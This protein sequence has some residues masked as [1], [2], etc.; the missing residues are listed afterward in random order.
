MKTLKYT[1]L[2]SIFIF[3]LACTDEHSNKSEAKAETQEHVVENSEEIRISKGQF[4][5]GDMNLIT[6]KKQAFSEGVMCTGV[7]DVP[8]QSKAI[9]SAIMGGYVKKSNLLIGDRVKKGEVILSIE[10]PDYAD[11][12]QHYL[13]TKAT[14]NYLKEDFERQ[15]TLQDE[16]INS[17][18]DFFKA[19]SD[20]EQANAK[21]QGLAEKLRM[22][23]INPSSVSAENISATVQLFAPIN[24]RISMVNISQGTYVDPSKP[25]MEIIALDHLH[26]ELNVYEKDYL[27]ISIGQK[28]LF[29]I[30]EAS[31]QI[32]EGEVHLIGNTIEQQ[33]RTVK[34]HGHLNT[35]SINF[36]VGMFIEA[37]IVLK[38]EELLAAPNDALIKTEN[39]NELLRLSEETEAEYIFTKETIKTGKIE[40]NKTAILYY[41]NWKA[42]NQY[43]V[44]GYHF[45]MEK[46]GGG[47]GH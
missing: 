22:I 23:S 2:A 39:S 35:D 8:P 29:S 32:F 38:T 42:E 3:Q 36:A 40:S 12:Q 46:N 5:A 17:E 27:K 13:E 1:I 6:L 21:L 45:V 15:K 44:G 37:Q 14:I 28:I 16:K 34:V 9:I 41:T 4:V 47:H 7:V 30:P 24:G 43:L 26:L 25:L 31:N 20:Y 18:K 11:L 10:N 19:K 33:S